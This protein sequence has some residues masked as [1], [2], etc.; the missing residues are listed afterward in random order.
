MAF[1]IFREAKVKIWFLVATLFCVG[2]FGFI[3]FQKPNPS[4]LS[5][6]STSQAIL[7]SQITVGR[8][9]QWSVIIKQEEVT[10]T[11]HLIK[12]P[13]TATSINIG[14]AKQ[15]NDFT[16]GILQPLLKMFDTR[17]T[18]TKDATYFDLA[19]PSI[20]GATPAALSFGGRSDLPPTGDI[21]IT[22]IT[23]APTKK[24]TQ[25]PNNSGKTVTISGPN[26]NFQFSIFNFQ[27][28]FNVLIFKLYTSVT[29]S[30]LFVTLSD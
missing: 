12:L 22:Y 5:V 20:T 18:Q 30:Y 28:I 16:A 21:I 17:I 25:N 10:D 2:V 3:N 9:V 14:E 11:K 7:T 29:L 4:Q 19:K 27:S 13:K 6:I 24:E 15:S 26:D 1:N 23:P 8:P